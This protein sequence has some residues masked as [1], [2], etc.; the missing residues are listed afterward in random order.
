M[1]AGRGTFD[2]GESQTHVLDHKFF[3]GMAHLIRSAKSGSDWTLNDLDSYNIRLNQVG[4]LPFFGLQVGEDSFAITLRKTLNNFS[5]HRS[6][7]NPP[8]IKSC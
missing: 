2:F 7:H 4:A 1:R 6:C 3:L 8:S 5:C